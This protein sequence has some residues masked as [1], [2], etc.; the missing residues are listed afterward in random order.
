MLKTHLPPKS[1]FSSDFGH[2]IFAS[3]L[4][5]VKKNVTRKKS[6]KKL[7]DRFE[8]TNVTIDTLVT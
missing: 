6:V 8:L 7:C 5:S 4:K 2:F 1:I 3:M